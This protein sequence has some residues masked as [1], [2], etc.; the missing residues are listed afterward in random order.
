MG[1]GLQIIQTVLE[2]E[3]AEYE[4]IQ[5]TIEKTLLRD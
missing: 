2:A 4:P 1:V 3:E 5:E